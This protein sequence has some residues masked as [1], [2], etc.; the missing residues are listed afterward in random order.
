MLKSRHSHFGLLAGF[1]SFASM[2]CNEKK[3]ADMPLRKQGTSC[4]SLQLKAT[5]STT[6]SADDET[7]TNASGSSASDGT[8]SESE[9]TGGSDGTGESSGSTTGGS[10]STT[11][12]LCKD[13]LKASTKLQDFQTYVTE[14]CGTDN[15]LQA[16]RKS[17]NIYTG[18]DAKILQ[19]TTSSSTDTSMRLYT[20]ALYDAKPEDYWALLRLQF[21]KPQ[22][23]KTVYAYDQD[24]ELHVNQASSDQVTFEYVNTDA[25]DPN[26]GVD[27][28]AK[29]IF[30]TLK[31]NQAYVTATVETQMKQTMKA[32]KGLIIVNKKSNGKLEV[33]TMSDQTYETNDQ[34]EAVKTRA[35]SALKA[36]QKRAFENSKK[37]DKAKTLLGG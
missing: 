1:I 9:Q 18:G 35:I 22:V 5:G 27:Y 19:N 13:G 14:L 32:L 33:I 8:C 2:G 6:K 28:D 10:S 24:A 12:D 37:A 23:Y 34:A 11:F 16:L 21:T 29:T 30:V 3:T 4:A 15:K 25:N 17:D 36:E 20:S 31:A 7:S 26:L